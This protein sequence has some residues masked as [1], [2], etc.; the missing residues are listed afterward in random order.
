MENLQNA[1][2]S[3]SFMG[4]SP[5]WEGWESFTANFPPLG[6]K[7]GKAILPS[8]ELLNLSVRNLIEIKYKVSQDLEK[9][10]S[11]KFSFIQIIVGELFQHNC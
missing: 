11:L 2:A 6:N 7:S 9:K 3:F 8:W 4:F 10:Y 5:F 1:T